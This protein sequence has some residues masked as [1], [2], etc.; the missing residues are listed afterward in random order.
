MKIKN[1][2]FT[3][4]KTPLILGGL[5]LLLAVYC[6][7]AW[8]MQ[9]PPFSSRNKAYSPGEYITNM[10]RTD[11][12]KKASDVIEKDPQQKL[13][14]PQ[15]DKPDTPVVDKNSGKQSVNVII[16]S[17]GI[18]DG[19]VNASGMASN[20]VEEGGYCVYTFTQGSQVI[21]K[22]VTTSPNASSTTCTR[23]T[24]PASELPNSGVW[25]VVLRYNSANADGIS[26]ERELTK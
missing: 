20:I 24:M 7:V 22:T 8:Y 13:Q 12:E 3:S 17:V 11:T 6:A 21:S 14:N 16:T 5:V 18:M 2:L 25:K 19:M 10:D 26:T 23:L 1:P 15:N 9:L 4:R